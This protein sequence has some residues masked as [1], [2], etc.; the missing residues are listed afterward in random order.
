MRNFN[1]TISGKARRILFTA[2]GLNL[3]AAGAYLYA[4]M[5]I[6]QKERYTAKL[7]TDI[8]TLAAQKENLKSAKKNV[9]ETAAARDLLDGYF[10]PKDG[11]VKFLNL[12]QSL[13]TE[14]HLLL[15]V[16]SVGIAAAPLSPDILEMIDVHLE[17]SGAWSDVSRFAALI[18]TLPFKV[19]LNTVSLAK[20]SE[21]ATTGKPSPTWKGTL[22]IGV[23]K[24]K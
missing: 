6:Q 9:S 20:S 11:V 16:T 8:T 21:V 22:N 10:V 17:V 5:G 2:L 19:Y 24:L 15:K 14:N 3:I 4:F 18:E 13:G 7:A 1:I 23:L 12:L